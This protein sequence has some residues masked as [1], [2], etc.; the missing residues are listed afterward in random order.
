MESS[1]T[2]APSQRL[3]EASIV[4]RPDEKSFKTHPE[5]KNAQ[6]KN[7]S[8]LASSARSPLPE[9]QS[10]T[11]QKLENQN[12]GRR[13]G[14]AAHDFETKSGRKLSCFNSQGTTP[15]KNLSST[16]ERPKG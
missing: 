9:D 3:N 16:L 10:M 15:E 6:L 1:V 14:F 2:A 11:E 12:G 4:Y 13:E 7:E 5:V 8:E